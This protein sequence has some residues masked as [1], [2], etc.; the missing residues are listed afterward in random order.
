MVSCSSP[1]QNFRLCKRIRYRVPCRSFRN[2]E[3][4]CV[5]Y[6]FLF[7]K[8]IHGSKNIGLKDFRCKLRFKN[9][10]LTTVP[11]VWRVVRGGRWLLLHK[12]RTPPFL[13]CFHHPLTNSEQRRP[14]SFL[15]KFHHLHFY[16][17]R[18]RAFLCEIQILK[19]NIPVLVE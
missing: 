8:G 9:R 1:S 5:N 14:C 18:S 4:A 7:I 13:P 11:G 15:F 3:T 16:N 2:I 6:I 12:V 10:N 17:T 19:S